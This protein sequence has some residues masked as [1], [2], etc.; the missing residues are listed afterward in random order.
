MTNVK[1]VESPTDV[2]KLSQA[3]TVGQLVRGS[4]EGSR[5]ICLVVGKHL[6]LAGRI[7]GNKVSVRVEP[8]EG[9]ETVLAQYVA[10]LAALGFAVHQEKYASAHLAADS[11]DKAYMGLAAF[12]MGMLRIVPGVALPLDAVAAALVKGA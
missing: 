9:K 4:S 7:T 11:E 5:Y 2:V 1:Q 10:Q 8:W 3:K 12:M 6:N